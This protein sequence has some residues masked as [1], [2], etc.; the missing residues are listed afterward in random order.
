MLFRIFTIRKKETLR[1]SHLLK[2]DA[3]LEKQPR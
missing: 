1:L 2:K 3:D